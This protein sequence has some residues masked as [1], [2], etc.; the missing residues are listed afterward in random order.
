[1]ELLNKLE[2]FLLA[3][4]VLSGFGATIKCLMEKKLYQIGVIWIMVAIVCGLMVNPQ[5]L[6]KLGELIIKYLCDLLE[7][8]GVTN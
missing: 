2:G 5:I 3:I 6:P 8:K 4:S 7:V 1:M